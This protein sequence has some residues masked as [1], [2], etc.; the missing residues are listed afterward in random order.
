MATSIESSDVEV[1]FAKLQGEDFE[2]Y[3]QTYS[4]VLGRNS[5][6]STVDVDLSSLGGGMNISRNHAR[7]FY[8]F[9]RRRF[10][11]EVLGKNGLATNVATDVAKLTYKIPN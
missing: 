1:G 10:A 2:Y 9:T 8:D 5:K 4:I 7:I 6:K 3:M 11:L